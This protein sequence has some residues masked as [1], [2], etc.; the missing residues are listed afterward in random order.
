[1][2]SITDIETAD[3]CDTCARRTDDLQERA[4]DNVCGE[5]CALFTAAHALLDNKVPDQP[6]FLGT[7]AYAWG[8]EAWAAGLED[9]GRL[10]LLS[11]VDGV[12]LLRLP[13]ITADVITYDG[14]HIPRA[15]QINVYSRDVKPQEFAELYERLLK[16]HRIHFDKCSGGSV[17]RDVEDAKLTLTVRTMKEL[18]SGRVAFFRAYPA[19]RIYS[20]PPPK[21]VRGF[22]GTLLGS[23]DK[24]M[25][26]GY[27][28]ALAEAGRRTPQN[29]VTGSVACRLGE[30]SNA[31][32]PPRERRPRITKALNKH[33]LT[34]RGEPKFPVEDGWR[35]DDTV[36]RDASALGPQLMRN[37]YHLQEGVKQ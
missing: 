32:T 23:T 33:L 27:G 20:F 6:T 30:S 37:L 13:R 11:S 4:G 25:F 21:L 1:M 9:Y 18:H 15:A 7:L 3:A 22:F 34:P 10:E 17:H 12:P 36:W 26:S 14:S 5:C 31:A 2:G 29:A 16:D 24:R 8:G 19:G 28:H 35:S